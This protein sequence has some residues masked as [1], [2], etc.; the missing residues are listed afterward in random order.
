MA[1]P[2]Y[3]PQ[4]ITMFICGDDAAAKTTVAGLAAELGFEVLGPGPLR[5]A[6]DLEP[7]A[8]L[9]IHLAYAQG[10]GPDFASKVIRRA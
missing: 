3:G 9:W 6:R 4:P 2:T 8:M 7:L 1:A 5:T 10:L